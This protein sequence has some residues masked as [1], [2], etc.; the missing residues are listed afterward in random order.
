MDLTL[1][2]SDVLRLIEACHCEHKVLS[3]QH[4]TSHRA[5]E[6]EQ[7]VDKLVNRLAQHLH[8]VTQD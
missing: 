1:Y 8:P 5:K 4:A 7:L 6:L 2:S 3:A